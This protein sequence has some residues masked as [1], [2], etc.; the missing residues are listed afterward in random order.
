MVENLT[1]DVYWINP[2]LEHKDRYVHNAAYLVRNE[3]GNILVD[4]G[5]FLDRSDAK[6]EIRSLVGDDGIDI[7]ILTHPDLPHTGNF[8]DYMEEW[9]VDEVMSAA[10]VPDTQGLLP[11]G[12]GLRKIVIGKEMNIRGR[13]IH[14]T[15][16]LLADRFNSAWIYDD[17]SGVYFTA[18]GFGHYHLDGQHDNT[19]EGI[20]NGIS[21]E[22]IQL[23]HQDKLPWLRFVDPDAFTEGLRELLERFDPEWIAPVHG[24]PIHAD[25]REQYIQHFRASVR[26]I[27]EAHSEPGSSNPANS[28]PR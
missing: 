27:T 26:N 21:P 8:W 2:Y 1:N 4:T 3:R 23:Y 10:A 14:A 11:W 20:E 15:E 28:M 5:S 16:A 6:T 17:A 25:D 19:S 22:N 7:I 13:Q 24:N 18:D 12:K 9:D